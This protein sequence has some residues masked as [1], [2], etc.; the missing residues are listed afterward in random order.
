MID[1]DKWQEIFQS[2][3]KHRLRAALTAFGVFWGIYMLVILMGAGKGLENGATQNFDISKN[4]V[5]VWTRRTTLPY[6]GLQPGRFIALKNDDMAAIRESVPEI[7]VIAARLQLGGNNTIERGDKSAAFTVYGDLPTYLEVKPLIIDNGR[8]MNDL[9][10]EQK[11]KVVVIGERVK[12]VMFAP[13]EDPIGEYLRI[14]GIM[15]KV[16]GTFKTKTKGE[17]GFE[18]VQSVYMPITTM[19]QAF[20]RPERIG[21]FAFLPQPGI[22]AKVVEDKVRLLIAQRH[23]VDP[24]D[25]SAIGSANV[26]EEYKQLQTVFGG[27]RGFSWLV[28]IGTIFAGMMGVGNIMMIIV[29]ERTKEIGIRKSVGATPGS[30]I[31]MIVQEALV[32]SGISGYLGL[33][34]G[35]LTVE[36]IRQGML[37]FGVQS[38]FFANPQ[39]DFTTAF[40]AV[41]V[42]VLAG[43]LA[44]LIPGLRAA[45]IN[46]VEALRT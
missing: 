15:F 23:K 11:R 27:I 16:V 29:K 26:E 40:V 8:F 10:V 33:L 22:P 20:N 36:G 13:D 7:D 25:R 38:D 19:Q 30:I 4:A 37:Q 45:R 32:L 39:I 17:D 41:L 18:D 46:P 35:C 12:E 31:A 24:N 28:A 1:I 43:V 14:G 9:D 34:A 3:S 44:G 5:F 42:L 2:I 6:A 21:W